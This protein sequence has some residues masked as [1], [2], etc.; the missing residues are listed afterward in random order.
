MVRDKPPVAIRRVEDEVA[1]VDLRGEVTSFS[2]AALQQAYEEVTARGARRIVLN[3]E[4]VEYINSA[5]IG[6][7]ISIVTQARKLEQ[8]LAIVWK[9]DHFRRIFKMVGLTKFVTLFDTEA[10]AVQGAG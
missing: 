7:L 9:N 10:A 2:E 3:F 4:Q 5:G 6:L 8:Q 1:V